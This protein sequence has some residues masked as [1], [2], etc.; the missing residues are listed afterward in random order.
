MSST[1]LKK[2]SAK[3]RILVQTEAEQKVYSQSNKGTAVTRL[4]YMRHPQSLGSRCPRPDVVRHFVDALGITYHESATGITYTV[5]TD[6]VITG[7]LQDDVFFINERA[8]DSRLCCKIDDKP[9]VCSM[10]DYMLVD[11]DGLSLPYVCNSLI[12]HTLVHHWDDVDRDQLRLL[13]IYLAVVGIAPI[14]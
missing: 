9:V 1:S 4:L 5:D 2:K 12:V 13:N 11:K 6:K 3:S 14:D 8:R 10:H 7:R